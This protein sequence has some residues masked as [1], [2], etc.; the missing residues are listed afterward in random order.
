MSRKYAILILTGFAVLFSVVSIFGY[1]EVNRLF[2][3]FDQCASAAS[4]DTSSIWFCGFFSFIILPLMALTKKGIWHGALLT[5]LV[6]LILF[7]P[8][9]THIKI[10][11]SAKVSGFTSDA[12]LSL[13]QLKVFDF[14]NVSCVSNKKVKIN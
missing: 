4:I 9:A 6:A 1:K 10:I 7:V 5:L 13:F 2:Q 3:L 11:K 14:Q 12:R 8:Y